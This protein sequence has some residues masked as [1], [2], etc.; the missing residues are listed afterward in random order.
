MDV[1]NL[2]KMSVGPPYFNTV[3]VPL[4][5]PAAFLIGVGPI[6]RWKHAKVPELG[7]PLKWA[8][9][10]SL[11]MAVILPFVIGGWHW[12][13]SLG[14]LLAIWIVATSLQKYFRRIKGQTGAS[15]FFARLAAPSRSFYGMHLAHIGVAVSLPASPW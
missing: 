1:L 13:A 3:F 7:R 2:G 6:A 14:L 10:L 9:A 15:N 12:R 5:A 4:M 8:F 11:I